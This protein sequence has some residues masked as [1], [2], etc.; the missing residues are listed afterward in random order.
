M[1]NMKEQ[2]KLVRHQGKGFCLMG[3]DYITNHMVCIIECL[4]CELRVCHLK[5]LM[6]VVKVK[7]TVR[8]L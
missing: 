2:N 4:L 1:E 7:L 6:E 3:D 5:V 8:K